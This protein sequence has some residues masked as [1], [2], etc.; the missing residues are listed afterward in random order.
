MDNAVI[1]DVYT[2]YRTE[3]EQLRARIAELETRLEQSP[4]GLLSRF[5]LPPSLLATLALLLKEPSVDADVF[6]ADESTPKDIKVTIHRLREAL[7]PYEIEI[8]S[9]RMTGYWIDDKDKERIRQM[10]TASGNTA[11]GAV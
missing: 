7:K 2:E 9:R 3:N 11:S 1:N 8:K 10:N 5:R 4:Q 6:N